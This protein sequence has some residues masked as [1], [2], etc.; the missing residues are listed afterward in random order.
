M[1]FSQRVTASLLSG[2]SVAF[3]SAVEG[4]AGDR[5]EDGEGGSTDMLRCLSDG[6]ESG[7]TW[8]ISPNCRSPLMKLSPEE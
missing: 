2:N 5:P 3:G 1:A 8:N 7:G 4:A 6:E